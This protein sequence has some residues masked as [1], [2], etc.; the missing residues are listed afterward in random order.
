MRLRWNRSRRRALWILAVSIVVAVA[1]AAAS[2]WRSLQQPLSIP[3]DT[4]FEVAHGDHLGGV[5]ARLAAEGI[6][7]SP[8]LATLYGRWQGFGARLKVGEYALPESLTL[9]E[10]FEL[11]SSGKSRQYTIRLLE[12]WRV[13]DLAQEF[14]RHSRLVRTIESWDVKA[15]AADLGLPQDS[16]EGLFFPDTYAYRKGMTDRQVLQMAHRELQRVLEAAWAERSD[17]AP[18]ASPYETLI[19]ASIIEKETGRVDERAL[20]AG[21]FAERLKRGMRLQTDPTV[22][23]GLGEDFDGNLRRRH[24]REENPFN[25]YF[26]DGLPPTPIALAG[27]AAIRAALHP[28][29]KG[30]LFFVARGDGSHVFSRNLD[31]HNKAVRDF[32]LNR[33]S[34]YRSH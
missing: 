28:E 13:R 22:I 3:A 18:V 29:M 26:I 17:R 16:A 4:V 24:L 27:E 19:L 31:D 7:P 30:Y 8:N 14:Q 23:Y 34:D 21:V 11:L 2:I 33:R 1:L 12:G 5:V 32:Q 15:L 6:V 25:T 20:I 9:H 10:L